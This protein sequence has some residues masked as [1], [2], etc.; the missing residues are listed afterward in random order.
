M[1]TSKKAKGETT[2]SGR[3]KGEEPPVLPSTPA[4]APD[5]VHRTISPPVTQTTI[6]EVMDL[7]HLVLDSISMAREE[8]DEVKLPLKMTYN[9]SIDRIRLGRTSVRDGGYP[10]VDIGDIYSLNE[11]LHETFEGSDEVNVY[12]EM[13]Y[14]RTSNR[15]RL[16]RK[17][18]SD[19]ES[20]DELT[21]VHNP[22]K[23]GAVAKQ[24]DRKQYPEQGQP[25]RE[26][27]TEIDLS[28]ENIGGPSSEANVSWP[29]LVAR[30]PEKLRPHKEAMRRILEETLRAGVGWQ[31][32]A[33]ENS[34]AVTTLKTEAAECGY[35]F[36]Y[37]TSDAVIPVSLGYHQR[38]FKITADPRFPGVKSN[39]YVTS[40]AEF[41][42]LATLPRKPRTKES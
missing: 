12:C 20:P 28:H 3:I 36:A 7:V 27:R 23:S 40:T 35:R 22:I 33:E 24:E 8:G 14:D 39:G 18:E 21:S 13:V 16:V 4:P 41:P 9:R 11:S 2:A 1:P 29:D 17:D 19:G 32:T 10:C 31:G 5:K 42:K 25:E 30:L 34:Q 6:W 15:V 26:P 37:S 38:V